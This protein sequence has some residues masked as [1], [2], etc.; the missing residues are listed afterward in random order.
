MTHRVVTPLPSGFKTSHSKSSPTGLRPYIRTLFKLSE[1]NRWSDAQQ[2][3]HIDDLE[4]GKRLARDLMERGSLLEALRLCD[5]LHFQAPQDPEIELAL[6]RIWIRLGHHSQA[7]K[8][9]RAAVAKHGASAEALKT[10][11]E[12]YLLRNNPGTAAVV[13][14]QALQLLPQDS[15]LL[16]KLARA[17]I[18]LHEWDRA[19][20]YLER[21]IALD[22]SLQA[23]KHELAQ[24]FA[25][26]GQPG[27]ALQQLLKLYEP[28]EAYFEL[29][30][31]CLQQ[32]D[33]PVARS[34]FQQCLALA[35]GHDEAK[36]R[37][38]E[39][40]SYIPPPAIVTLLDF[41]AL[42]ETAIWDAF[43][44]TSPTIL[45]Q[46]VGSP[47]HSAAAAPQKE[48]AA[49]SVS[50]NSSQHA[51]ESQQ[52]GRS[53]NE[54]ARPRLPEEQEDSVP[55]QEARQFSDWEEG[56]IANLSIDIQSFSKLMIERI[57]E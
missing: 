32:K 4:A 19:R 30:T 26:L 46:A 29:G 31:F 25:Q 3:R 42:A 14:H 28:A 7:L 15:G 39:A 13:F 21:T 2:A 6:A 10:L 43:P 38:A 54:K 36:L 8:H 12:V 22:G 52:P 24:V 20:E 11:G 5:E 17:Y 44:H 18:R 37:L 56:E 47:A 55:E 50:T 1:Q 27:R 53:S 51:S 40:E 41:S 33:W 48:P 16:H 9:A 49:K 45:L 34:A 57:E 23:A 35:P